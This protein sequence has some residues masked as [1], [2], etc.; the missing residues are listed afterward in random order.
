[1]GREFELKYRADAAALAAIREEFGEFTSIAME[2][3]YYDTPS[4]DLRRMRWTLRRRY[5]N[6]IS[7]CTVKTPSGVFLSPSR[8][9]LP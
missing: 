2:T 9:L 4:G 8:C 1:M 3:T 5:E 6:G 7:V